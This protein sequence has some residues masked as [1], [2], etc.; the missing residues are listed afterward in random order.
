L[1]AVA[2]KR[3]SCRRAGHVVTISSSAGLAGFEFCTAYSPSKY[4]VEGFM[5]AL[6]LEVAP[7][8]I[9]TTVVNPGFFRTE[10][11]TKES[12]S[13]AQPSIDDLAERGTAQR[14]FWTSENGQQ[15]R[16]PAKLAQALLTITA[17][18][19]PPKRFLAGAGELTSRCRLTARLADHARFAPPVAAS[20]AAPHDHTGPQRARC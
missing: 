9:H 4:G 6:A 15:T 8:G 18:E 12:T 5:E 10:L 17:E 13:F 14:D 2:W 1:T 11:L 19:Q 3:T 20:I 7:F 16:D